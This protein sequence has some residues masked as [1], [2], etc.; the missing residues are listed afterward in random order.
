MSVLNRSMQERWDEAHEAPRF[1]PA[2]PHEQVVRWVF[3]NFDRNASSKPK[4]LDLGCGAGRHAIF[5]ASEGFEA[6]ACDISAVGLHELQASAAQ[7]RVVV[8]TEHTAG[9]DLSA[10]RDGTFDAVLCFGVMYYMSLTE[11]EQMIVEV[12]RV[13]RAGGKFFCVTRSDGDGRRLHA[14]PVGPCTWHI[15]A[16]DPGAPSGIEEGM[17]MLFFSKAELEPMFSSFTN[18]CID[19]MIYIHDGFADDDWVITASKP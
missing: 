7:R 5:L 14:S 10:Y 16:L 1:R 15:N 9:H 6:Y 19:R 3:R 2:Y 12:F 8:H 13:L 17:D 4:V 18:R 11:A